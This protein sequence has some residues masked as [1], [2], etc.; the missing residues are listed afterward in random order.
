MI[1]YFGEFLIFFVKI[2]E[3]SFKLIVPNTMDLKFLVLEGTSCLEF[4]V[5]THSVTQSV[6]LEFTYTQL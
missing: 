3:F 5:A 4:F 6:E 1:S 2:Q